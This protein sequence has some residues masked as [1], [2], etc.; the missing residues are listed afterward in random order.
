MNSGWG[1]HNFFD[2]FDITFDLEQTDMITAEPFSA[3]TFEFRPMQDIPEEL[4]AFYIASSS[5]NHLEEKC[6]DG[7]ALAQSD[8]PDCV[9]EQVNADPSTPAMYEEAQTCGFPPL[10]SDD[11]LDLSSISGY[12]TRSYFYHRELFTIPAQ[13]DVEASNLIPAPFPAEP[14]CETVLSSIV[15][16][17]TSESS[18]KN[19]NKRRLARTPIS[20]IARAILERY[21][22]TDPYPSKQKLETLASDTD[23]S[24]KTVKNWFSNNRSRR[25]T[26]NCEFSIMK[27]SQHGRYRILSCS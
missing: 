5:P 27:G 3:D 4:S 9:G 24:L 25:Q 20:T 16:K 6:F 18:D 2:E 15:R 21:L 13:L 22:D 17:R 1:F 19:V 23:L 8:N 14:L 26:T 12:S 7:A 11:Q 10:M